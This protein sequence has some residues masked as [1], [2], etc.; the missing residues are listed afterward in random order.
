MEYL[1]VIDDI[2]DWQEVASAIEDI[3]THNFVVDE[4]CI[5]RTSNTPDKNTVAIYEGTEEQ[6]GELLFTC[7]FEERPTDKFPYYIIGTGKFLGVPQWYSWDNG[8]FISDD[9]ER[10]DPELIDD[11]VI[12][13]G[14]E[15]EVKEYVETVVL[16]AAPQ[17]IDTVT[18][19][20]VDKHRAS[21]FD[22][23]I[24]RQDKYYP[25]AMK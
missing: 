9:T 6:P 8:E 22:M 16:P 11:P 4:Y 17:T 25:G 21:V 24:I 19:N 14:S 23:E 18:V 1:R 10:S 15:A 5:L 12:L 13:Y 7:K 20:W 2:S 3:V